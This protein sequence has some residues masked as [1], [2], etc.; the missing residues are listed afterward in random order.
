VVLWVIHLFNAALPAT[1]T[2]EL[3]FVITLPQ[4]LAEQAAAIY[5]KALHKP[6]RR[7]SLRT[8]LVLSVVNQEAVTDQRCPSARTN[9]TGTKAAIA[10]KDRRI[11]SLATVPRP[12]SRLAIPK[13]HDAKIT[14]PRTS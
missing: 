10:A 12:N 2:A 8:C 3:A 5:M 7:M 13:P 4:A 6:W 1:W 11:V 14:A 9:S